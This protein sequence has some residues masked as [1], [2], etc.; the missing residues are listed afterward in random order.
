[1]EKRED[2]RLVARRTKLEADGYKAGLFWIPEQKLGALTAQ[3]ERLQRRATKLRLRPIVFE[4]GTPYYTTVPSKTM[5]S[6]EGAYGGTEWVERTRALRAEVTP[7]LI[8][9]EEPRLHGWRLIACI[10]YADEAEQGA[11]WLRVVPDETLPAEYRTVEPTRC[12]HCLTKRDR[13]TVF[14][15]KH[16]DGRYAVVGRTCL[17]DFLGGR[18]D[19][20]LMANQA[21]TLFAV[22]DLARSMEDWGGGGG[23]MAR[24]ID[25]DEF[26]AVTVHMIT[27]YGWVS[28]AKARDSYSGERAT[29]DRV[30][31]VCFPV[32]TDERRIADTERPTAD[33]R[34]TA[35][36]VVEW[37]TKEFVDPDPSTLTDYAYNC[38]TILISGV[39]TQRSAGVAASLASAYQRAMAQ[40]AESA[41]GVRV[42]GHFGTLNERITLNLDFTGARTVQGAYGT[43]YLCMFRGAEGLERGYS[44][45]WFGSSWPFEFDVAAASGKRVK[46]KATIKKH[47]EFRGQQETELSRVAPIGAEEEEKK[48]KRTS[49]SKKKMEENVSSNPL[50]ALRNAMRANTVGEDAS[51]SQIAEIERV[52]DRD[53]SDGDRLQVRN[54]KPP[55]SR[56]G[57][58]SHCGATGWWTPS[59]HIGPSPLTDHDRPQGGRCL[60]AAGAA[61]KRNSG[62]PKRTSRT[63]HPGAKRHSK[64]RPNLAVDD[65]PEHRP[66]PGVMGRYF[67]RSVDPDRYQ[68]Q[69]GH[70]IDAAMDKYETFHS[71]HPIDVVDVTHEPPARLVC[72]GDASAVSYKTDKWYKDGTD[73]DYKHLHGKSEKVQYPPGKGVMFY[74]NAALAD[75]QSIKANGTTRPPRAYP[76]TWVRLGKFQGADLRRNGGEWEE[77]DAKES[78]RDCWLLCAPDGKMLA[79]YSPKPQPDGSEGFLAI[80]CGGDLRVL[81]DGI[82]G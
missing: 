35:A 54:G 17:L 43:S 64:P 76:K 61:P 9:G 82:D 45:K 3:V 63:G 1:M 10:D 74:E 7:V 53:V 36:K 4:K 19:P 79:I 73:I 16:D 32:T 33:E 77:V 41:A 11:P 6:I 51:S 27:K 47:G 68:G 22:F 5:K 69:R 44:F 70:D 42:E 71:K 20:L 30:W 80:M 13:A 58:C 57:P 15:L 48:P 39:V 59:H 18:G 62:T 46:V 78:A 60:R 72:I 52:R 49:R 26:I 28:R 25:I 31:Q 67:G 81:K 40:Q 75:P 56:W 65:M 38:R 66:G 8:A 50:S 55:Q 29:V 2:A 21:E 12:D 34:A 24:A 14:V 37:A 23:Y